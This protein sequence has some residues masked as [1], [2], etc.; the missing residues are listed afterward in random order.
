MQ[1]SKSIIREDVDCAERVVGKKES[2]LTSG[3][4]PIVATTS[5]RNHFDLPEL[6]PHIESSRTLRSFC[7]FLSMAFTISPPSHFFREWTK[8]RQFLVVTPM[9]D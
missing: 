9:A 3:V 1:L 5:H 2:L 8:A 7:D 6:S 4:D